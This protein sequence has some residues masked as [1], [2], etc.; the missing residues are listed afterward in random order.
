MWTNAK[1]CPCNIAAC[2]IAVLVLVGGLTNARADALRSPDAIEK[3]ETQRELERIAREEPAKA[4]EAHKAIEELD[5]PTVGSSGRREQRSRR[6]NGGRRIVKGIGTF[7]H[8]AS[9]ALLKGSDPRSA[10]ASCSGTLVGCDK[11]LTAAHCVAPDP[12]FKNYLVFFQNAGFFEVNDI[13]WQQNQYKKGNS[14]ADIALLTLTRPVE[15]IAPIPLNRA[16]SPINGSPGDIVGFGR[17]GGYNEDYGIKREGPVVT[18]ACQIEVANKN[19]L[20]WD[21]NAQMA[22]DNKGWKRVRASNTC[23][24]DSGG[25]LFMWDRAGQRSVQIIVGTTVAGV[26]DNCLEGDHSFDTDVFAHLAWIEDVGEGRLSTDACGTMDQIDVEHHVLG[27]L[28]IL[29]ENLP[30][31][32]YTI[33]LSS[34][35]KSLR[36]SMNGEDDGSGKND[37]D[38]YVIPG[39]QPDI[40]RAACSEAGPGQFAFCEI[41]HPAPGP[42]TILVRRKQGEGLAQV[43]VTQIFDRGTKH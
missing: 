21:F 1:Y 27:D 7:K 41:V 2:S 38:L 37:F 3:V 8:P 34:H 10:A 16:A 36:V 43:A 40:N 14:Y 9:G 18:T 13:H 30:E 20:C 42:W 31:K 25:G 12:D 26:Q 6:E 4:V 35:L 28:A 19:L 15:G 17:T 32:I 33:D 5:H 23:N 11:F 24:G 29:N 39:A 22:M